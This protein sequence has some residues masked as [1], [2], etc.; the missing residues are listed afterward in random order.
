MG[1]LIDR[2][3]CLAIM[4]SGSPR[5]GCP[6]G[7]VEVLFWVADFSLYAPMVEGARELSEAS[8]IRPWSHRTLMI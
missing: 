1:S 6:H 8:F 2:N 7:Q 5:S 4:E 3:L